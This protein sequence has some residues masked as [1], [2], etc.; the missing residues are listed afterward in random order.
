GYGVAGFLTVMVPTS[1]WNRVFLTGHGFWTTLQNVIVGPFIAVIAFV[2]SIGNIPLAAALWHG[3]ISFGGVIAFIFADLITIPLLLIYRKYYGGRLALRLLIWFWAVMSAAGLATELLFH[4]A[5]LIPHNRA[6]TV[7]ETS[8]AW[9]YTTFL[10]LAFIT[11]AGYLYWLYRNRE[12][13]GGGTGYAIDPICGMQVR[14][15]DAP[16]QLTHE[17]HQHWFCSDRCA[18]RF[19]T[20]PNC[21]QPSP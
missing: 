2:C 9:N 13:L 20:D 5:G 14:T 6:H 17:D 1:T 16:A 7:V 10:N 12:R 8:F 18:E 15:A 11:L 21:H 19:T 4:A 3:G